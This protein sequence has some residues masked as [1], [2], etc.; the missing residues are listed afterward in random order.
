MTSYRDA[1][2]KRLFGALNLARHRSPHT[3]I[4]LL[5]RGIAA[6]VKIKV[7]RVHIQSLQKQTEN[8]NEETQN[9]IGETF[10]P[11][12]RRSVSEGQVWHHVSFSEFISKAKKKKRII[13]T[14]FVFF[15]IAIT[16]HVSI[17]ERIALIS[18]K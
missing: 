11:K 4:E 5:E 8:Q 12:M 13:N 1:G 7:P 17:G 10:P 16:R 6:H 3:G 2:V 9:V 14:Q 15:F 18:K